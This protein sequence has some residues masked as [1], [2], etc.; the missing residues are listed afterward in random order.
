MT[1]LAPAPDPA[2]VSTVTRTAAVQAHDVVRRY[3]SGR[4]VGPIDLEV[5][6]GETVALMG[7]NGCGKTT[8]LRVLATVSRPQTGAVR[9]WGAGAS[10]ARLRLGLALDGALEDTG[11]TGRQATHF[12]CAQWVDDRGDVAARTEAVLN[13]LGLAAAADD[14]VGTYSYGMRR[15]LALAAALVHR[16][17]LALL[18]EPTAGLDPDGSVELELLIRERAAGGR[19]TLVAS[20]DPRFV[21]AVADR[22]AIIDEGLLVRCASPSDLLAALPK[23]RIAE[24]VVDGGCDLA[25]LSAV[26]GVLDLSTDDHTALQVRF[27][28]D[29]TIAALVAAADAPGGRLRELRLRRPDLADCFRDVTGHILEDRP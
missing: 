28:G 20:N 1:A 13:R 14:R 27:E 7:R 4:G 16:P 3:R 2:S 10:V 22:V 12:W 8:L 15:R 26:P 21:E 25:A 29:R 24:L 11:L 19:C 9:W 18:D 23:G 17:A 6:D 5:F